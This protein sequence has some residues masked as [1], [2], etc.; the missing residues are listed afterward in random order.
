MGKL[1]L[2]ELKQGTFM[3]ILLG[4]CNP[5]AGYRRSRWVSGFVCIKEVCYEGTVKSSFLS[6]STFFCILGPFPLVSF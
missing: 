6:A 4:W 1:V 5:T 2:Q 3:S